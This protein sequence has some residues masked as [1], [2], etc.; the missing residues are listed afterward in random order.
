MSLQDCRCALRSEVG[1][2]VC[3]EPVGRCW[4]VDA[5]FAKFC[6]RIFRDQT[7]LRLSSTT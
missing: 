7:F 6:S 4:T 5:T 1:D 3:E 2:A